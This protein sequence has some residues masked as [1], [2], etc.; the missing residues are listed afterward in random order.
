MARS[1]DTNEKVW[2]NPEVKH[3]RTDIESGG[4]VSFGVALTVGLIVIVPLMFWFGAALLKA[5]RDRKKSDLPA[6]SVDDHALPPEPRLEFVQK[7]KPRVAPPRAADILA[8]QRR[9]LKEGDP[10]KGVEPIETAID[11]LAAGKL[12]KARGGAK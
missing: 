3:E 4:V 5:E 10:E 1:R 6:A 12:L 9:L 7:D 2:T 11:Q 8:G